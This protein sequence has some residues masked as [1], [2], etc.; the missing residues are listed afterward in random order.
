[1]PGRT[2]DLS[3]GASFRDGFPHDTFTWLRRE[4]PIFWHEPTEVTP[5]GEGFWVVSR[6]ADSL[7]VI[8]D[9]S[10]FSSETGGSR[11]GGGTA[12]PDASQAGH[13]L[14]MM[15]DPRHRRVRGLVN[16]GFTPRMIGKLEPELRDRSRAI[17]DAVPS[18]AE[19]DFVA[20]VARENRSLDSSGVVL[21]LLGDR[22]E[23]SAPLSVVEKAAVEPL[24]LSGEARCDRTGERRNGIPGARCFDEQCARLDSFTK[25]VGELGH[26][27]ACRVGRP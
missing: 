26:G 22:L 4:A 10:T 3:D 27:A 6:H 20:C 2:V 5:S 18:G 23:E 14:N 21:G 13:V 16:Q 25:S 17:L 9:P 7:A 8:R 12:I 24:G 15:D 11:E 19:F 1:M